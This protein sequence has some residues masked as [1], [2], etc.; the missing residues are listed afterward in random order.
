MLYEGNT[1]TMRK[2]Q[3]AERLTLHYGGKVA[4][5]EDFCSVEMPQR[6]QRRKDQKGSHAKE[7]KRCKK[8]ATKE[9]IL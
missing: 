4:I 3:E 6:Q 2:V 8:N 9:G 5:T 7:N 1:E